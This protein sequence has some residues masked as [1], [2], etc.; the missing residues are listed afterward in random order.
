MVLILGWF[1]LVPRIFLN[2]HVPI[3]Q[4]FKHTQVCRVS[5]TFP[6]PL[7]QTLL[8]II[9]GFRIFLQHLLYILSYALDSDTDSSYSTLSTPCI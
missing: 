6:T 5:R 1:Y 9:I 3:G 8:P 2:D 4:T 7:I